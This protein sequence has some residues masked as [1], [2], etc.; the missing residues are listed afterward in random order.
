MQYAR[1]DISVID[2]VMR[3]MAEK[4]VNPTGN[5]W[6]FA[7]NNVLWGQINSTLRD[8]LKLWN[9]TPTLLYSKATGTNVKAD[10][11]LKVGGTFVT[12]EVMG[13]TVSFVVD[14]ALSKYYPSKGY[15]IC[16]DLTP[17]MSTGNPAVKKLASAA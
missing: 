15:G 2:L 17:D 5:T 7:V 8:W 16:M 10:N 4:S 9:S 11:P 3:Q 12:Y 14:N 1:L 13:N 6:V